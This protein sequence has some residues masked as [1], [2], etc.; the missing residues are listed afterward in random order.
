MKKLILATI[1]FVSI[2]NYLFAQWNTNGN[3]IYN[4]NSGNVVIGATSPTAVNASSTLFPSTIPKFNVVTGT[5][6]GAYTDLVVF[7]HPGVN[8][9]AV[10]RQIGLLL[11]LSYES[12]AGESNKMGGMILESSLG[13]G[14][15]PSLSL[16]TAN[17][18]RLTVDYSGNV[19][20]G[21]TT[22]QNKLDV[23]GTIH[24]KVVLI[25]LNGWQDCVFKKEYRLLPLT[26]VKNYIDQNQHLPEIP[27][28]PEMI[29][30]GL[31][32]GEMNKLL[33]KKVEELT[34][35]AI[36][37][38]QKDKEKDKLLT[39]LQAQIDLLKEQLTAVQKE[40]KK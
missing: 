4:S 36:E 32:V 33:M 6:T 23:N 38:E 11:K 18:R 8:V 7:N 22:P 10:Q 5:G 21:T 17:T 25:D 9:D 35:Y 1:L 29:K 13:Y 37:N 20:I 39:T 40:I 14:N 28:E 12:T 15:I 3:D 34:L 26:E 27:S 16:V 19:G 2:S 31:D 30:N 24:S